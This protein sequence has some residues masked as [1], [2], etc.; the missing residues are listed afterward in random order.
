QRDAVLAA[1]AEPQD[2]AAADLDPG[3]AHAAQ[4]LEPVGESPRRD[5]LRI[6]R[7]G[8]VEVVVVIIEPGLGEP[9]RLPFAQQPERDA[10]LEPDRLD[11][12][13]HLE[14]RLELPILRTA[15]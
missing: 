1:F 13:D 9:L 8:R 15:V 4:R 12:A 14:D 7:L 10:R 5:D 2:A 6:E 11:L 3:R